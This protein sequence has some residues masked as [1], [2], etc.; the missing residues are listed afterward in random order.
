M[1]RPPAGAGELILTVAVDV[2]PPT[3][4]AGF[5]VTDKR[6]G[7]LTVRLAVWDNPLIEAVTVA[8]ERA[9]TGVVRMVNIAVL[10][11]AG[12]NTEAGT[13]TEWLLLVSLTTAPPGRAVPLSVTVPVD[14][15]PPTT[16]FGLRLSESS[17]PAVSVRD[18]DFV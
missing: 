14:D 10:F 12:T 9:A 11:P 17:A 4:V 7:G 2:F 1:V 16:A 3:R 6:W 5:K 13:S 18:A 15:T 8:L